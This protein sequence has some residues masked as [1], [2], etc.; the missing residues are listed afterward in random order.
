MKR[1]EFESK[2]APIEIS[3]EAQT[4]IVDLVKTTVDEEKNLPDPPTLMHGKIYNIGYLREG[5]NWNDLSIN[6]QNLAEDYEF[7]SALSAKL[8]ENGCSHSALSDSD[9]PY[10]PIFLHEPISL[11]NF[12]DDLLRC[13]GI[14]A[15]TSGKSRYP[16]ITEYAVFDFEG[17][18]EDELE[19]I[20]DEEQI[21]TYEEAI[22]EMKDKL[23]NIKDLAIV[24]GFDSFPLLKIGQ[25]PRGNWIGFLSLANNRYFY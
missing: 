1:E 24:G 13:L 19:D 9:T 3:E 23:S 6:W 4:R 15:K 2:I 16:Q 20:L 21:E 8:L 7:I 18:D 17:V 10:Y 11:E 14:T 25:T 12:N 22:R 5:L